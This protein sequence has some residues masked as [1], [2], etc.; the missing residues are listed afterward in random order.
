M[1]ASG[2]NGG[3]GAFMR[4]TVLDR[5]GQR[6]HTAATQWPRPMAGRPLPGA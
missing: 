5:L 3:C 4:V 1:R 2:V 6:R